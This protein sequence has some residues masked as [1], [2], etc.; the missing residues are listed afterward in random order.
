[1]PK[2]LD[3]SIGQVDEGSGD[4]FRHSAMGILHAE[5]ALVVSV[6]LYEYVL[7]H[8]NTFRAFSIYYL[9]VHACIKAGT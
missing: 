1:M 2:V 6:S 9:F 7:E 8:R 5:D 4:A 3:C